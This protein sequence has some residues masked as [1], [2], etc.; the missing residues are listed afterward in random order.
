MY[1]EKKEWVTTDKRTD[2]QKITK[3]TSQFQ[4]KTASLTDRIAALQKELA[5]GTIAKERLFELQELLGQLV[6]EKQ[7]MSDEVIKLRRQLEEKDKAPIE[8]PSEYARVD[9]LQKTTVRIVASPKALIKEGIPKLTTTPN[10]ISG[11]IKDSN[12]SLLPNLIVTVKDK[13]G[14]PVRALK[15]NKL[16]QFAASTPLASGVYLIEV[17]DPKQTFRFKRIEVTLMGVAMPA[18]EISAVSEKDLMRQK[19]AH[20]IFGKNTL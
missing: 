8:K 9:P 11:I 3:L 16:G 4:Q 5:A 15:T 10:V 14:V 6:S 17:E 20:E 12:G 7:R 18:L 1:Q 13:E 2:S 19:L